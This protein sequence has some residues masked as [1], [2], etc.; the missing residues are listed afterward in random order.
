MDR[1][2][3][4]SLHNSFNYYSLGGAMNWESLSYLEGTLILHDVS[5]YLVAEGQ[6]SIENLKEEFIAVYLLPVKNK[7]YIYHKTEG[8]STIE[9]SKLQYRNYENI[10]EMLHIIKSVT[11]E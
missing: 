7:F 9:N 8:V 1:K 4:T 2:R 11:K 5:F 6:F 10:D 3:T